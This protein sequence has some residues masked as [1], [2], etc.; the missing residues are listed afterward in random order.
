[1][2]GLALGEKFRGQAPQRAG[3]MSR[4]SMPLCIMPHQLEPRSLVTPCDD[5][6]LIVRP[7]TP[8]TQKNTIFG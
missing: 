6:Q 2:L 7:G 4:A 8:W 1:M 5:G 3:R